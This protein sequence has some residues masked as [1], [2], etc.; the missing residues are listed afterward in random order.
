MNRQACETQ[1]WTLSCV[2]GL[3]AQL[4]HIKRYVKWHHE[5][6]CVSSVR[7]PPGRPTTAVTSRFPSRNSSLGLDY[8][9]T[10][11]TSSHVW[12][13]VEPLT[14]QTTD[15][16]QYTPSGRSTP[17]WRSCL[18]YRLWCTTSTPIKVSCLWSETPDRNKIFSTS[19]HRQIEKRRLWYT[20]RPSYPSLSAHGRVQVDRV[21]F[22]DAWYQRTHPRTMVSPPVYFG[23][24]SR[25]LT[26]HGS[27]DLSHLPVETTDRAWP[28]DH[29]QSYRS[30]TQDPL[31]SLYTRP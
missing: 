11:N 1:R 20:Q 24:I 28:F 23:I 8:Y 29:T 17:S 15:T 14:H 16:H 21:W 10:P 25:V 2:T 6:G 9:V 30:D 27:M 31:R 7:D 22:R 26:S 19:F 12:S 4:I 13:S 18:S 3:G 5:V